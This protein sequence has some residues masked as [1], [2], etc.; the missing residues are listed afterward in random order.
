MRSQKQSACFLSCP[1]LCLSVCMTLCLP[2]G[3]SVCVS[4]SLSPYIYIYIIKKPVFL[5]YCWGRRE[6]SMIFPRPVKCKQPPQ[7]F[8]LESPIPFPTKITITLS[9][10]PEKV[11]GVGQNRR[12]HC[13]PLP[14]LCVQAYKG[15]EFECCHA[16]HKRRFGLV[17]SFN[18]ISTFVG[19]LMPK[20]FS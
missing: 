11:S 8:E 16:D 17:Y 6:G 14:Q 15:Y 3:L 4:L 2:A 13:L 18:G 7:G 9:A 19:Y 5:N 12:F 10:L 1:F 20:P